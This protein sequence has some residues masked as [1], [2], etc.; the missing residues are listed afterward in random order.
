M[1]CRE[2]Y[3]SR[4]LIKADKDLQVARTK[5][6]NIKEG[7]ASNKRI[8]IEENEFIIFSYLHHK[9]RTG[10]LESKKVMS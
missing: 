8:N 4:S 6:F 2:R 7:F 5:I 3:R 10:Y 1:T 9:A